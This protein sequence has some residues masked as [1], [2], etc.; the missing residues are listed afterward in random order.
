M[1]REERKK[2]QDIYTHLYL[3]HQGRTEYLA[4]HSIKSDSELPIWQ[5]SSEGL[6]CFS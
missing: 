6:G 3:M 2:A 4:L 1:L 5:G